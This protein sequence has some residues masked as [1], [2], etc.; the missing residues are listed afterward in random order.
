MTECSPV[1]FLTTVDDTF[2]ITSTTAGKVMPH[3]TAKV[4]D[5]NDNTVPIGERGELLIAGYNS[6]RGYWQNP[7]KTKEV[8]HRDV[9]GVLWLR[10]GDEV[11]IDEQGYCRVTGRIKDIIIRG[12][13]QVLVLMAA[14]LSIQAHL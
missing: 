7:E 14:A 10:T 1:T 8:L 4:V 6:F 9:N 5:A 2:E 13:R 12:K 3:V 11:T